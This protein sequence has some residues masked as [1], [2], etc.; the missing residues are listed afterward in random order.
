MTPALAPQAV[1][2]FVRADG[3]GTFD[4]W[5]R[6]SDGFESVVDNCASAAT[7]EKQAAR[8]QAKEDRAR[9]NPRASR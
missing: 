3:C 5:M 9:L 8:W 1:K 2:Y 6:D 7:A 4:I